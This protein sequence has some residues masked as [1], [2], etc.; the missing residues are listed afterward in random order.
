MRALIGLLAVGGG[1]GIIEKDRN[2]YKLLK[3]KYTPI[4]SL[5]LQQRN[6]HRAFINVLWQPAVITSIAHFFISVTTLF[7]VVLS[8]FRAHLLCP[9]TR[10][11]HGRLN[12]FIVIA[13]PHFIHKRFKKPSL[14]KNLTA[15]SNEIWSGQLNKQKSDSK[16]YI[17][18]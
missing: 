16:W 4:S 14:W 13:F 7:C 5:I 18:W 8:E 6:H 10:L 15:N 1:L 3:S 2:N 12:Y 11:R 9:S 17:W